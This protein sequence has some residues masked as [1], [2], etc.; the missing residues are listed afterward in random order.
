[1]KRDYIKWLI[2]TLLSLSL[3]ITTSIEARSQSDCVRCGRSVP[4]A[5]FHRLP[6][7]GV[8]GVSPLQRMR[9]NYVP[10]MRS[11]Y[12]LTDLEH[13]MPEPQANSLQYGVKGG[14]SH[15]SIP[16]RLLQKT[17]S[18]ST[19]QNH[20]PERI[21]QSPQSSRRSVNDILIPE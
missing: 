20:L 14:C 9:T 18:R 15:L 7:N 1:M 8:Q 5:R 12:D 6:L 4:T 19:V 2:N 21:Q 3:V 17:A 13:S 16:L 11:P 10:N